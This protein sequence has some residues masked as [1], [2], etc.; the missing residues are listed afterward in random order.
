MIYHRW[1]HVQVMIIICVVFFVWIMIRLCTPAGGGGGGGGWRLQALISLVG[2]AIN[3][4]DA[5]MVG[6][7]QPQTRKRLKL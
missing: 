3:S 2:F 6:I 7:D 1:L 4:H 5:E